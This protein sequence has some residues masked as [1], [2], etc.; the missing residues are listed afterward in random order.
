MRSNLIV[1]IIVLLLASGTH[2]AAQYSNDVYK[3]DCGSIT[4]IGSGVSVYQDFE[5]G[6]RFELPTGWVGDNGGLGRRG[7]PGRIFVQ[8]LFSTKDARQQLAKGT[9]AAG[10]E[11][12]NGLNWMRVTFTDIRRGQ[13]GYLLE[14]DGMLVQ[15]AAQAV[16]SKDG[17][18]PPATAAVVK[19]ILSTFSF[20]EDPYRVDRQ[21]AA[22]K[23]GDKLGELT[24]KRVVYGAGGFDR[25]YATIEF[26]GH[27]TL[28]GDVVLPS[29]GM[30]GSWAPYSMSLDDASR[31]LLP[32]LKCP[33]EGLAQRYPWKYALSFSNQE[34]VNQQFGRFPSISAPHVWY[35]AEAAV[36]VN[37]VTARFSDAAAMTPEWSARLVKVLSK[38]EPQ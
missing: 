4:P 36:V 31:P 12:S 26:A 20:T 10:I 19:Q 21:L 9:A 28:S 29:P 16:A 6:V 13:E 32:E 30:L 24:V 14:H 8:A 7:S 25:P 33:V 23:P 35:E 18:I 37:D 15:V 34:F 5:H 17:M 3:F 27:L 11:R 2:S 22:L 38:K 1:A